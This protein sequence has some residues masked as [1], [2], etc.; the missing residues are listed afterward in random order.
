MAGGESPA[1]WQSSE[2]SLNRDSF[3][4]LVRRGPLD[5]SDVMMRS[6]CMGRAAER[7]EGWEPPG[8]MSRNRTA[9]ALQSQRSLSSSQLLKPLSPAPSPLGLS[10]GRGLRP[11]EAPTRSASSLGN[12]ARTPWISMMPHRA[13]RGE[14]RPGSSSSPLAVP[15]PLPR[16][17]CAFQPLVHPPSGEEGAIATNKWD[18]KEA[19]LTQES[20][21][22]IAQRKHCNTS[23][24]LMRHA[25]IGKQSLYGPSWQPA[26]IV[27]VKM[28]TM[29][30]AQR[31][32][33]FD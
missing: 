26:G 21:N 10:G 32:M 19:S 22:C 30:E 29:K 5:I 14:K 13:D 18:S 24:A 6:A 23:E 31:S 8:I 28:A 1:P 4:S 3:N 25:N 33:L 20:F 12:T 2:R 9:A 15:A 17:A 27:T 7:G 16:D 11:V